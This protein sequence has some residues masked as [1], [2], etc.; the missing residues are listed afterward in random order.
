MVQGAP[1]SLSTTARVSRLIQTL[2]P[3]ITRSQSAGVKC[4][5][6]PQADLQ[7]MCPEWTPAKV[8]AGGGFVRFRTANLRAAA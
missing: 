5:R 4:L 1:A 8:V 6:C 3:A 2:T 7:T